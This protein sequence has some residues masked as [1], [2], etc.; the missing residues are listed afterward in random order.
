MP[1]KQYFQDKPLETLLQHV[2]LSLPI[3]NRGRLDDLTPGRINLVL[4]ITRTCFSKDPM[5]DGPRVHI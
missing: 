5:V 4:A 2:A 1:Y 3:T